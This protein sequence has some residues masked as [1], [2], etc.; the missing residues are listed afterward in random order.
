MPRAWIE[1]DPPS[2]RRVVVG[3]LAASG[4]V[5]ALVLAAWWMAYVWRP[6][7]PDP[8]AIHFDAAGVADGSATLDATV[9]VTTA[10]GVAGV[11]LMLV[12]GTALVTRPRPLRGWL[13]GLASLTA[14]A[15]ASLVLTLLPN[16]GVEQ[17]QQAVF[18]GWEL[19]LVLAVPACAAAVGW[20]V[21]ARPPRLEA[22]APRVA[23]SAPVAI[24]R[25]DYSETQVVRWILGMAAGL[26]VLCAAWAIG[27]GPSVL[28]LGALVALPVGWLSVYR[29]QVDDR[30]VTVSF[31][32]LVLLRRVVPIMEIEGATVV[33]LRP[34][35]WGGW[36]YRTNGRDWAVVLRRGP[37]CRI[38]LAGRRSLSVSSTHASAMA[39]RVNGAVMRYWTQR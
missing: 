8:V 26:L 19:T 18:S 11:A 20:A 27:L 37:G 24:E 34:S 23:A 16:R 10:L 39:G 17:W 2:R 1:H 36:G 9:R 28:L 22:V 6:G 25:A 3:V 4:F 29:Y 7:L 38:D 35:E 12:V 32:P 14:L 13:T 5:A 30:A 33:E 31:G 21:S 15:P